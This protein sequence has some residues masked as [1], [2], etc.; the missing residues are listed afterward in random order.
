MTDT[1]PSDDAHARRSPS[2]CGAKEMELTEE[3]CSVAGLVYTFSHTF[4]C[5]RSAQRQQR[6]SA[7]ESQP[8]ERD[9]A[10]DAVV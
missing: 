8:P 4:S 2:S 3:S 9:A 7:R 5:T 10:M 6:L 1:E